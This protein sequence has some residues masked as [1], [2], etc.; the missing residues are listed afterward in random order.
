MHQMKFISLWIAA[1]AFLLMPHRGAAVTFEMPE[2]LESVRTFSSTPESFKTLAGGGLLMAFGNKTAI[3]LTNDLLTNPNFNPALLRVPAGQHPDG[4]FVS[5]SQF[6]PDHF[7]WRLDAAGARVPFNS[8]PVNGDDIKIVSEI[9]VQPDKKT[10]VGASQSPTNQASLFNNLM[11]RL[12]EDGS[13]DQNFNK[14]ADFPPVK[15]ITPLPDGK[16]VYIG[17]GTVK[18]LLPDGQVDPA[19]TVPTG[20]VI[21]GL[22]VQPDGKIVIVGDFTTINQ[23]RRP[24][25]ARL[26][27]DGTL[28]LNFSPPSSIGAT[29]VQLQS[30]GAF[31]L[32]NPI[33]VQRYFS[34][35]ITDPSFSP[36]RVHGRLDAVAMD[37]LDRIYFNDDAKL[38]EYSGR[39]RVRVPASDVPLVFERSSSIDNGWA[40]L[41][42]VPPNTSY[43]Y[44]ISDFPGVGNTFYRARPAQ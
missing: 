12:N 4:G 7:F 14:S 18:R 30:D 29:Q 24:R 15:A 39:Y 42:T 43:D 10:L 2:T 17:G 25:F 41:Q 36:P 6:D 38:Y 20:G 19:F 21:S 35:G 28:D 9:V 34:S 3:I 44:L 11:I 22:A 33:I 1:S 40:V 32:A 16:I 23:F 26:N 27:T 13:L 8:P 31:V 5:M 37:F